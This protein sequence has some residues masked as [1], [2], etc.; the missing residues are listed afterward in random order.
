MLAELGEEVKSD[1]AHKAAEAELLDCMNTPHDDGY[2][3]LK[4]FSSLNDILEG[5]TEPVY[6][7]MEDGGVCS[8]Q[9]DA[10]FDAI[11]SL[12]QTKL[13]ELRSANPQ[14]NA[15]LNTDHGKAFA[16]DAGNRDFILLYAKLS[17]PEPLPHST[18]TPSPTPTP[19]SPVVTIGG[20][21]FT[22]EIADTDE[23]RSKGLGER[24]S[25][26]A[27]TGM[28]FLF[29]D[30]RTS[31]FW[32]KGMRFPLDFVWIGAD[33]A[34]VDLT[35]NVP[36]EP[37]NTPNSELE[38]FTSASPAAYTFEINAGEVNRFGIAVGDGV[39]FHNIR[40]ELAACCESGVCDE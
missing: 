30:G 17:A 36:H 3:A 29:P 19:T 35:E 27:Q 20:V 13:A 31:S 28:L 15:L 24:D 2:G 38:I 39:Q 12:T 9:A 1:P 21:P 22:A 10:M 6:T 33:C 32:M 4:T 16:E 11:E 23:L 14:Y 37:P 18:P 7:K 8:A 34:V 5:Y 40:S 25:L 26:A